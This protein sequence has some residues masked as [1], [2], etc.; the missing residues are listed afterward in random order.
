[1]SDLSLGC[2]VL[3]AIFGLAAVTV[4]ECRPL[5]AAERAGWRAYQQRLAAA[6]RATAA[7]REG[8]NR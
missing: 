7:Q 1:M 6:K 5:N 8:I 2:L 4:G 3:L